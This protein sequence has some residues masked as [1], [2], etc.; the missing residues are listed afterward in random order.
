[1]ITGLYLNE[2]GRDHLLIKYSTGA[3]LLVSNLPKA[4]LPM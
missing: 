4:L 1:M 3:D 2:A